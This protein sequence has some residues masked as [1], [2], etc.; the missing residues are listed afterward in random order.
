AVSGLEAS[1]LDAALERLT[2]SGLVS[3]RGMPPIATYSFKHALVQ[4]AAYGTLLKRQRREL[5]ARIAK[6][7]VERFPAVGESQP[8]VVAHHCT[9]AGLTSEAIAYWRRA[10]HLA[11]ARSAN[12][13][14]VA[15][16]ERALHLLEA[17]PETRERLEL[18]I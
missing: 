12:R 5:H 10:G 16:L 6:L 13:E 4:D 11:G 17:Q 1:D 8:E 14:A 9:E 15:S 7:L 2:E 18:A 3:R